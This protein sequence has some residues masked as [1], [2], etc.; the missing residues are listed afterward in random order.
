[1]INIVN[2]IINELLENKVHIINLIS[3]LYVI[4]LKIHC[5]V[6]MNVF[7][8]ASYFVLSMPY[9][10]TILAD[11]YFW[12]QNHIS[13]ATAKIPISRHLKRA[14]NKDEL[15]LFPFLFEN[16]KKAKLRPT[17][18]TICWGPVISLKATI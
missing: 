5:K 3:I 4:M 11:T 9:K 12:G 10:S 18:L 17:R 6:Y 15:Y 2:D 8:A 14:V 16:L 1:M 7:R 13:P